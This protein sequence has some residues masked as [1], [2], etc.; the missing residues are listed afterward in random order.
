M[1]VGTTQEVQRGL[2]IDGEAGC[3]DQ[4]RRTSDRGRDNVDRAKLRGVGHTAHCKRGR[5]EVSELV[6][7]GAFSVWTI[8]R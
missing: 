5:W 8:A 2:P 6:D 1:V 7:N 4:R 3:S